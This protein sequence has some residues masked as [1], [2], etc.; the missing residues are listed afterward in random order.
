MQETAANM[1]LNKQSVVSKL[2]LNN[3]SLEFDGICRLRSYEMEKILAKEKWKDKSMALLEGAGTGV[4]GLP[5]IPF[6]IAAVQNLA[7]MYGD[8]T[9]EDPRELEIAS[10]ITMQCLFP[11]SSQTDDIACLLGK[12]GFNS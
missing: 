4:F 12:N 11:N 7:L 3:R 5:C 9:K 2:S 1:T 6:N 10:S 8:D